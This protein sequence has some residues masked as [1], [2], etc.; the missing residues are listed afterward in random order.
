MGL[1]SGLWA[2]RTVF[3]IAMCMCTSGCQLLALPATIVGGTFDLLGKALQ[4]ASALPKPPP[5]V[6]F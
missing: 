5:G 2:A 4:L 1:K 6:F 3:M